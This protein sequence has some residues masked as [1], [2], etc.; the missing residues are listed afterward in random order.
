MLTL[1]TELAERNQEAKDKEQT[2]AADMALLRG[3][4]VCVCVCLSPLSLSLSLSL[5]AHTRARARAHTHTHT[6]KT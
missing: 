1:R 2:L 4:C 5:Y 3:V 6:H